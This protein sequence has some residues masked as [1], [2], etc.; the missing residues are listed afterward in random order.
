MSKFNEDNTVIDQV[1][2]DDGP[3]LRRRSLAI[4]VAIVIALTAC[5][6]LVHGMLD[7]RWSSSEDLV[8]RGNQL[9]NVPESCGNWV[10]VEK[11]QL[12]DKSAEVLRV[13]GS[14]VRSYRHQSTGSTVT[15]AVLFGPRGPIA[16]HTP[17]ICYSSVSKSQC[18]ERKTKEL[19]HS[20]NVDSCWSVQFKERH[21][22]DPDPTLDVWYGWSDGG[23]WVA[24]KNPR[25]WMTD[26]LYKL[27]IA[28][29]VGNE[30]F[31]PCEDFLS[32]F[33][34]K[35]NILMVQ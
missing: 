20:E 14:T 22:V 31:R 24:S 33:L 21:A 13:Y 28:G 16:V 30:D 1:D 5:S 12:E 19:I 27:Q 11:S 18:G 25:F 8:A 32:V 23:N 29:P 26:N 15:V 6:G 7:G 9:Q 35:V 2:P 34:P 3:R 17:E 4:P 10:E